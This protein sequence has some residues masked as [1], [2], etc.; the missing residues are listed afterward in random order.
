MKSSSTRATAFMSAA[1]AAVMLF[2][3]TGAQPAQ[4]WGGRYAYRTCGT[5][6][7][8]SEQGPNY[9]RTMKHSGSCTSRLGVAMRTPNG[10]Q[11]QQFGD[12]YGVQTSGGSGNVGGAHW[13]CQGCSRSNT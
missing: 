2:V 3:A 6:A 7:I 13:G 11:F 9:A 4:A 1:M 12:M 8:Y 5:N 10:F